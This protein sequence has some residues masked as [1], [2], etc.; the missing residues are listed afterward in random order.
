MS[1]VVC[2]G[3]LV[4]DWVSASIDGGKTRHRSFSWHA[5]GTA[6]NVAWGFARQNVSAAVI[7]RVG[8]DADGN[9]LRRSLRCEGVFVSAITRDRSA[10][11]RV[12]RVARKADGERRSLSV[13]TEN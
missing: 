6:A 11:T 10:K 13:T 4:V 12:A 3:E 7:A 5:A 1:K 8:N 2:L 9:L